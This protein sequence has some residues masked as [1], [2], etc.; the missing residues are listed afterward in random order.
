MYSCSLKSFGTE[1][2][3][4]KN[5][6]KEIMIILCKTTSWQDL[7]NENAK[8]IPVLTYAMKVQQQTDIKPICNFVKSAL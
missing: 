6:R 1:K 8:S 5:C 4:T 2:Q 3:K 7:R